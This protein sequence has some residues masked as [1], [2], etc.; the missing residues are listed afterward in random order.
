MWSDRLRQ[1]T[2][3]RN[4]VGSYDN[5]V[6]WYSNT[7]DCIWL[8]HN[9]PCANRVSKPQTSQTHKTFKQASVQASARYTMNLLNTYSA[10]LIILSTTASTST[11]DIQ[12]RHCLH[13]LIRYD[14]TVSIILTA[15]LTHS[16]KTYPKSLSANIRYCS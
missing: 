7:P 4:I 10:Q 6:V 3:K 14:H 15:I 1:H 12:F 2:H 8:I 9:N 13:T 5:T 11:C 16:V